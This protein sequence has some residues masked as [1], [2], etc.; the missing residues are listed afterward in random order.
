MAFSL[1]QARSSYKDRIDRA[2]ELGRQFSFAAEILNFYG[3][4][5]SFQERMYRYL[6]SCGY[7]PA[8]SDPFHESLDVFVLLPQFRV[9]LAEVV[10]HAP[11]E[12]AELARAVDREGPDG[13]EKLLNSFWQQSMESGPLEFFGYAFLQP[14]AEHLGAL[15]ESDF[16][17]YTRAVCPLCGRKPCA[18]VLR[19][20]GDGAKRS[21]ICS[22][23][24]SEWEYRRLVCPSCGDEDVHH[25]PV[26]TAEQFRHVR[27]E[28][29]D[30]CKSYIKTVDLTKDGFAVPVVDELATIPL[31]L[32]AQEKGY[33]KLQANL[34]GT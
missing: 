1:T 23:C 28:A 6:E 20:E 4:I 22:L 3:A 13:W 9:L 21:L 5:A 33:S 24:A 2:A 10:H 27:V 15:A 34:L 29:C 25:L 16:S 26:Y 18:G 17:N 32:W 19:P 30:N 11:R 14:L 31:T 8:T 12:L 7:K